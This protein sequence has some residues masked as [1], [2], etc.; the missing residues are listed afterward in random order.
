[1]TKTALPHSTRGSDRSGAPGTPTGP[2]RRTP[3]PPRL[4]APAFTLGAVLV[5]TAAL[6]FLY[7]PPHLG[8]DPTWSLS[9]GDDLTSGRLPD[10]GA[11]PAA[12]T[13]HPLANLLGAILAPLGDTA[14]PI[15]FELLVVA[16]F[17]ALGLVCGAIGRKLFA[18]PVGAFFA[19]LVLTEP[20][21]VHQALIS[22]TDVAFV[23]L[24]L[25]ALLLVAE[26]P[27]RG[28]APLGLLVAAGLLRPEGWG[29]AL[30][31]GA[32]LVLVA[33]PPR[34]LALAGLAVLAPVIWMLVDLAMTGNPLFSLEGTQE[35]AARLERP[36]GLESAVADLPDMIEAVVGQPTFA[37]GFVGWAVALLAFFERALLPSLVVLLGIGG[38]LVLGVAN[39]PL[40]S[41]YMVLP[42]ALF[43]LFVAVLVFGWAGLERGRVRTAWM[44]ASLAPLAVLVASVPLNFDELREE[45]RESAASHAAQ[46]DLEQLV[47]SPAGRR[48][49]GA[50][51][52]VR[53]HD[54]RVR[55]FVWYWAD[56]PPETIMNGLVGN[57]APGSYVT[58]G[59][60]RSL[61]ALA[62][63]T[64]FY[65]EDG[66]PKGWATVP[67]R[68]RVVATTHAWRLDVVGCP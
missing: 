6:W 28:F 33:K 58:P 5:L 48:A 62:A 39:L 49:L 38:W 4:E 46:R 12:P 26:D 56:I 57:G 25:G 24:A 19:V 41:R 8:Y 27:R 34:R 10:L 16:S 60:A 67:S 18:F 14:A 30:A 65:K 50:C 51:K 35:L 1:M 44:V 17:A 52:P 61:V 54:F 53:V 40:L 20:V 64:A 9:W 66:V 2:S 7:G 11:S 3:L 63:R 45:N 68:G 21:L 15:A 22:S 36:R 29:F 23:A 43:V 47:T 32:Y 59:T 31:Y 42:G 37:L 55:P 13:P